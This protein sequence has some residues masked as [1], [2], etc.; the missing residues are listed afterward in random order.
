MA[1]QKIDNNIA[2]TSNF[3]PEFTDD[4]CLIKVV[5]VGG[6]GGN[7]VNYMYGQNIENV[8]FVVANT[9]QQALETS[10]VP[11]KLILGY[12]ICKGRGAGNNPEIGRQCAEADEE[13]IRKLF[14]DGTEMVFVTAGMGGGTGTGAA[15]VV[16]RIAKQAG[17]LT[18][19][20]VTVPFMFEGERKILKAIEGAEEMKRH[21]DALLVINNQNLI[22]LYKDLDFFNAFA[23]A[24]DTLANAARSISEIISEKC[25]INVDFEDVRTTLT[26]AGTAIISTAS[27]EGENR[28]TDAI[29]NALTSPLLKRHNIRSASR[30]LLK[31][32]VNRYGNRPLISDEVNQIT[33]FTNDMSDSIDVKWGIADDPT[34]GDKFKITV[35][36][37]G[38]DVTIRDENVI[39]GTGEG[40]IDFAGKETKS[41]SSTRDTTTK[42]LDK[43][44]EV[45]G[46]EQVNDKRRNAARQKYAVLKP[47]QFDD[48]EVIALLERTPTFN[49]DPKINRDIA[50]L[51]EAGIRGEEIVQKFTESNSGTPGPIS[52]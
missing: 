51:G 39:K 17:M 49:R 22:E 27:G 43:I 44:A 48:H 25:Y 19:G 20:I 15:P 18:I 23:K 12:S 34:L 41:E 8:T 46:I 52:F 7:A 16:A 32:S 6:G 24:D 3:A 29:N 37:A 14:D 5:G 38:F 13:Q 50:R 2:D 31:F 1:N 26:D 21:V 47:S 35:L 36:A 40:T 33:A 30:L 28:V 4:H 11:N 10:P 45:Y 9:D 42:E